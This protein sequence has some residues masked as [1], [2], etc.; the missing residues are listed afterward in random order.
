MA[1]YD[2]VATTSGTAFQGGRALAHGIVVPPISRA[3]IPK[4]A[5][6]GYPNST[7][8]RGRT[9]QMASP[10]ATISSVE[11]QVP[12]SLYPAEIIKPLTLTPSVAGTL[13][14]ITPIATIRDLSSQ[15]RSGSLRGE[16]FLPIGWKDR[17]AS[18]MPPALRERSAIWARTAARF[19]SSRPTSGGRVSRE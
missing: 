19:R 16:P 9:M 14:G 18:A 2:N 10:P 7:R 17:V 5:R 3:S 12:Q 1:I 8:A 4:I 6:P 11:A 15:V 13:F